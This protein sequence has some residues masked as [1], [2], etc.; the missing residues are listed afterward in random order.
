MMRVRVCWLMTDFVDR[1]R[2]LTMSGMLSSIC[3]GHTQGGNR[4]SRDGVRY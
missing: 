2:I 1:F 3:R 4:W